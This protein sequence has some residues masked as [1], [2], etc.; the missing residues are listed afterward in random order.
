[1]NACS[2]RHC[3]CCLNTGTHGAQW[4]GEQKKPQNTTRDEKLLHGSVH[5][6]KSIQCGLLRVRGACLLL[7]HTSGRFQILNFFQSHLKL[8][9]ISVH[10]GRGAKVGAMPISCVGDIKIVVEFLYITLIYSVAFLRALILVW[11]EIKYAYLHALLQLL[12]TIR[13][14]PGHLAAQAHS[15]TR[16]GPGAKAQTTPFVKF[17]VVVTKA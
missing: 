15:I 5:T 6:Y 1:M 7:F 13:H 4:G 17:S 12:L 8:K 9:S 14:T 3:G 2:G 10:A 16:L 11:P